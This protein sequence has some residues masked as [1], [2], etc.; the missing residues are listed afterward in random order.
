MSALAGRP[1]AK[2]ETQHPRCKNEI[3]KYYEI[4][5]KSKDVESIPGMFGFRASLC[6]RGQSDSEFER[7]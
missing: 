1:I 7:V 5:N 6:D 3:M 4:D 2:F